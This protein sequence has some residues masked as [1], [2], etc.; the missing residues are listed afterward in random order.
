MTEN[1]KMTSHQILSAIAT[2][3]HNCTEFDN[4]KRFNA[5]EEE[6]EKAHWIE[7]EDT[8][9][10]IKCKFKDDKFILIFTEEITNPLKLTN[11]YTNKISE[12]IEQILSTIKKKYKDITGKT[13]SLKQ[14]SDVYERVHPISMIRQIRDYTIVYKING[15]DSFVDQYNKDVKELLKSA[16]DRA[17]E[18]TSFKKNGK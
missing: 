15:I 6:K 18:F 1:K 4:S 8:F 17:E 11:S 7:W 5:Y 12:K 2:A 13:L 9:S 16:I 14:I 10:S 3:V